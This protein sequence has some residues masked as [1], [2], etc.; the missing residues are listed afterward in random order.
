MSDLLRR[1]AA[2]GPEQRAAVL[3]QLRPAPERAAPADGPVPISPAQARLWLSQRLV[4]ESPVYHLATTL[5]LDGPL[6]IGALRQALTEI[7]RRH[8]VLRTAFP[9]P[10]GVPAQ[11]VLP[12]SP[13][14]LPVSDLEGHPPEARVAE[15]SAIE[16]AEGRRRFDLDR[17]PLIRFRLLRS[18]PERHLLTVV[19]HHLVADGWSF[20]VFTSELVTLYR[21][22]AEGRPSPL[23]DLPLQYRQVT[24]G[25]GRERSRAEALD[26]WRAL[27]HG[28]LPVLSLPTDRPR[29][30][31]QTF[32][33]R[34]L[35]FDLPA[36][37]AGE[38]RAACARSGQTLFSR[39]LAGFAAL[40]SQVG[41]QDDLVIG[42][43]VAGRDRLETEDMI[44]FFVNTLP[45]RI[46]LR[47]V[48]THDELAHRV[49][50]LTRDA[51]RHQGVTFDEL[52]QELRPP[53][54]PSRPLLRQVAFA[55]QTM[56][57]LVSRAGDLTV[58]TLR[59]MGNDLGVA[60]LDL[61]L[62]M[63][64]EGERLRGTVEYDS[65]LFADGTVAGWAELFVT[66]LRQAVR[67]PGARV[68][69]RPDPAE[70]G[71]GL[72][73]SQLMFYFG[74]Q[75]QQDVRLYYEYVTTL[76]GIGDVE[77]EHLRRAVQALV[78]RS[79]ALRSV[80]SEENGVPQRRVLEHVPV[81]LDVVDL[82]D[83][84]DPDEALRRWTAARSG[85]EL[86]L[87]RRVFDSA[88][89]VLRPGHMVWYL[90]VHHLVTDAWSTSLILRR[91]SEYYQLSRAGRLSGAPPL[92]AYQE[93]VDLER[94]LRGSRRYRRAEEFWRR[95]LAH[96]PE[97]C[98]F[99][100]RGGA[101]TGT[102]TTRVTLDLGPGRTRRIRDL[103]RADGLTSPAVVLCGVLFAYLHRVSGARLLRVG[104]PFANRSSAFRDTIGLFMVAAPLQVELTGGESLR[105]LLRLVQV[106][107]LDSGR[108]LDHPVRNPAGD[109]TYDVYF[110]YQNATFEGFGGRV[111]ME[112]VGSGHSNDRLAVQVRDVAEDGHYQLDFDFNV[113]C[114]GPDDRERT[115][116]H[117]R[118]L[119][120]ALLGDPDTAVARAPML[121]AA[122]ERWLLH[123]VNDTTRD[124]D[125]LP[126]HVR[127]ERQAARTP[128]AEAVV[129][130]DRSLTYAELN[131]RANGLA[132]RLRQRG[133]GPESVVGV[134]LERSAEL[135]VALLAVLKAG[136]AYLPL[137]PGY[138][139][140]RLEFMLADSG[141]RVLLT[142]DRLA[143]RLPPHEAAVLTV[144]LDRP[145]GDDPGDLGV[146]VA[147]T[148][149]AYV[150]YT[151]GST[152]RP[153][154]VMI[155][156]GGIGNRL[157]WMQETYRL[158]RRDRV[159][160]KTPF[161]FDVSVW[162]FFWPL[163]TG[164]CLV[165][166][167]PGGHLDPAYLVERVVGQGV[168]VVH[169]VPSMLRV[170]LD[171]PGVTACTC[172]TRVFASGEALPADLPARF[173]DLLP[174]ELHNLYGPTEA[175]VDVSSWDCRQG[176][177]A[178]GVP[179]GRPVANTQL[180][181][182]D[183]HG[184]LV[185]AGIPGE[186]HI[187]GVQLAR[188]YL[189]RPELTGRQFVPNP[190]PPGGRLYRTGDL[191]RHLPGGEI[192]FLGRIDN[193]VKLRGF[194]IEL[195][196]VEA[197]LQAHPEVREAC[198][199]PWN[200]QLVA[201]LVTTGGPLAVPAVRAF[202]ARTLPEHM[203]PAF[204]VHLPALPVSPNG[205]LDRKALPTPERGTVPDF[206]GPRT[207][208]EETLAGLW[209]EVLG[210]ER[211][212]IHDDFFE[213]GGHSL[214]AARLISAV[215]RRLGVPVPLAALFRAPTVAALGELV[216]DRSGP[217]DDSVA[218]VPIRQAG[219]LP[220]IFMIHPAGGDVMVY[221]AL[222]GALP[223]GHPVIGI[224]SR[225]HD[226]LPE[227]ASI[228]EM[229]AHYAAAVRKRQPTGPYFLFGWSM[230]GVVAVSVA[231]ELEEQGESVA[232]VGLLDSH[233]PDGEPD[234]DPLLAPAVAIADL[235]GALPL[236]RAELA[237]LRATL[238]GRP[239]PDRLDAVLAWARERGLPTAPLPVL[240]RQAEFA[241]THEELLLAHR[242][243][244]VRSPL[245]VWWARDSLHDRRTDWGRHSRGG[246]SEETL[247]GNHFTLL[248][249]PNVGRLGER[250]TVV[251]DLATREGGRHHG[252]DV[253]AV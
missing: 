42:T 27:L 198:V 123:E 1:L 66:L 90:N 64:A 233:L 60:A 99:Y 126:L 172:L 59:P 152:G 105:E 30:A 14:E 155:T 251:L 131:S 159:L 201:Y 187:G 221:H 136:G 115:V 108:H 20:T 205:K 186:L 225:L 143:D 104:T 168:T 161:S 217:P 157:L 25:A 11:R 192:E 246:V 40:L 77:A 208:T 184:N 114:F 103:T 165:M 239:L 223:A 240:R 54:D 149:L 213:L 44:G 12:P 28:E 2:L 125:D 55:F 49:H 24:P 132:R 146:P 135:V 166:A 97:R 122:E 41:G 224:Q 210:V 61:S 247:G 175:A 140:D 139:T 227:Y 57:P 178:T 88:L 182:L 190:F 174:A 249:P 148:N 230:G 234:R 38:L 87:G 179:I 202:L 215:Q 220:P 200:D 85:P 236:D 138:P 69:Q 58:R 212:G 95:V 89:L 43:P 218:L 162:E 244:V 10:D 142:V 6:A 189:G 91:V 17:G 4:P 248:R 107:F 68:A 81:E 128:H 229:A 130:E 191:A 237:E 72:T 144:D 226:G 206:V 111:R 195:G 98:D 150:M 50:R 141:V 26:F 16:L 163:M 15:V 211:V 133:V 48:P 71:S 242:P 228:A 51:L 67:E 35:D 153:K 167:R 23:P 83:A 79:D 235:V 116:G 214:L 113:E 65:D 194:R 110:N 203:L 63:W 219:D 147:G 31:A 252:E 70:H 9:A 7:I 231:A 129:A 199:H 117:Y 183:P 93:Y 250:L 29:P 47:D 76:F 119:L 21:A 45:L 100:H 241:E 188:G 46:D 121:S 75:Y 56:P 84:P 86:D 177:T 180:H 232:F 32:N 53:R 112:L 253:Q 37:L 193:Q 39:L 3:R 74:K 156:H 78:D 207:R 243:Q 124:Y 120:D 169:F 101:R 185:P 106:A 8:E 137:E 19:V 109:P 5:S 134:L 92:P 73:E 96:R 18:A 222:A 33:G 145:D 170:F 94:G 36:D 102:R 164:A 80:F 127:I 176:S 209:A 154:A 22:F 173:F 151:S 204:V 160:Q 245:T 118:A 34:R 13:V 238:R 181:V 62:H 197:A 196:E 171:T 52:V 158:D 216:D 82:S